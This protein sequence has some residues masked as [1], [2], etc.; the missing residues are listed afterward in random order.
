MAAQND[1]DFA[2]YS[3]LYAERF[4]GVK[5]SGAYR[6]TFDRENWLKD[7]SFMFRVPV[8][9]SMNNLQLSLTS[10]GGVARF[11]QTWA[12]ARY[13]DVGIKQMVIVP[14]R[15]GPR[16]AREEMLT[17]RID[18]QHVA[19]R[20]SSRD[21]RIM[22]RD[23]VLLDETGEGSWAV[24]A[25][26]S[27]RDNYAVLRDLDSTK[28]P[29]ELRALEGQAVQVLGTSEV[30]CQA[31]I[32]GFKLRSHVVPHF[33]M[34][35][36]WAE[37]KANVPEELWKLGESSR[38]VIG[39]LEPSCEHGLWAL[40]AQKRAPAL[41]APKAVEGSLRLAALKAFRALPAYRENQQEYVRFHPGVKGTW[42]EYEGAR[43]EVFGFGTGDSISVV[44]VSVRAGQGCG[45]FSG[46]L[47][48]RFAAVP[49][50]NGVQLKLLESSP[51]DVNPLSAIDF[52]G[53]GLP[54]ILFES[55]GGTT[56]SLWQTKGTSAEL[57]PLLGVL[58]LD[59]P[60]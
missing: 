53:D 30:V 37:T 24:G 22:T 58:S 28:L 56:R 41:A 14:T 4:T 34:E 35:H 54:E 44:S 57:V 7:R 1:S 59:C 6:A 50:A 46:E 45:E 8:R 31:K 47:S 15:D 29:A 25:V 51:E 5:R 32:A 48:A 36:D 52:E 18:E 17:S 26:Q 11:E 27:G 13:K 49:R 2:G 39:I 3:V 16:I 12:S 23:G 38:Q 42:D 19:S 21:M 10:A 55:R 9:V 33:G 20:T 43:A 40:P 60:C